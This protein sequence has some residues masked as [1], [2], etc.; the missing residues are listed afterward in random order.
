MDE[1]FFWGK[2]AFFV[3]CYHKGEGLESNSEQSDG[4]SNSTVTEATRLMKNDL[5]W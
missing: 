2:Y 5:R 4:K 1:N 3:Q